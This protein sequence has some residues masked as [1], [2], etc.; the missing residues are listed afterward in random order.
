MIV[1]GTT[2]RDIAIV[3]AAAVV[4]PAACTT[5]PPSN[6]DN[7]CVIFDEHRSWYRATRKAEKAWN[8]PIETQLAV[9][10]Q[11]SAF[12][13]KARPARKSFLFIFPGARPSSARGYA[14]AID[15]TWDMYRRERRPG[16][17][18]DNFH[19]AADF[20]GWYMDKTHRR[21]GVPKND[22]RSHY[23]AYHEGPT[24]F[25]NG[26][27]ENKTWLLDTAARVES[28]ALRYAAQLDQCE[29][30]FKRGIPLVPFI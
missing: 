21:L 29:R 10:R 5:P 6:V 24:N 30:R 11:E 8:V 17:D 1:M 12:D 25:A 7:A 15:G 26:T 23:L 27:H 16:A 18:R 3:L 4:L 2:L 9:I 28:Q 13:G 19:H 14:Q 20:V 22:V